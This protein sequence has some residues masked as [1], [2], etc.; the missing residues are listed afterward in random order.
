MI[1]QSK[2]T[3]AEL[4]KDLPLSINWTCFLLNDNVCI[5]LSFF[6]MSSH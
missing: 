3:T 5:Q 4:I 6:S 1:T 2:D